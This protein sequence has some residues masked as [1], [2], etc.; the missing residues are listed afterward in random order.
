MEGLKERRSVGGTATQGLGQA[1]R[2]AVRK[3][4]RRVWFRCFAAWRRVSG[5]RES[6]VVRIFGVQGQQPGRDDI[7]QMLKSL[8]RGLAPQ[9][10]E[11]KCGQ[12]P[13]SRFASSSSRSPPT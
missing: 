1:Q 7:G 10:T 5:S 13:E 8:Y 6:R 4:R 9:P 2:V 3:K 12:L 11:T